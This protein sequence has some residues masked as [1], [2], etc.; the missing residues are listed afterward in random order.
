M[1]RSHSDVKGAKECDYC[2]GIRRYANGE[3]EKD[4][5]YFKLGITTNKLKVSDYEILL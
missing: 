4:L 2:G 3:E 1:S 5:E